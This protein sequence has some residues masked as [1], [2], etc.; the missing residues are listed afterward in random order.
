MT[1]LPDRGNSRI[2][3]PDRDGRGF[4]PIGGSEALVKALFD[5]SPFSTV[6]YDASGH[7]VG[8]NAAFERLFRLTIGDIPP[9]YSVLTD[10]E[11]ERGGHLSLVRRAFQGDVSVLPLVRY[12]ASGLLESAATTWTQGH[13]FPI[14]DASGDVSG[15]VLVH[16][17]LTDRVRAE[18][19]ERS[20]NEQLRG[21]VAEM[22]TQA[23]Q[24]QDQA[25]EMETQQMELEQQAEDLRV[26]IESL[27]EANARLTQATAVATSA[28][29]EAERSDEFAR[30][31]LNS[32]VDPFVVYD[33]EW[34]FQYVNESAR[35]VFARGAGGAFDIEGAVLWDR[36]PELAGTEFER[37]M[38]RSSEQRIPVTFV[39]HYPGT[40]LWSEV[41]CYP[42]PGN[43]LA[44]QWRDITQRRQAEEAR[45]FLARSAEV[46]SQ[47]LERDAIARALAGLLIPRLADWCSIQLLDD[48][49]KLN[50]TA[51]AHVDPA[52]VAWAHEINAR[53]PAD[54]K[55]RTGAHEV[56][57]TGQPMLIPEISDEMLVGAARDAEHLRMLREI[58]FASALTVPLVARGIP[59]GAMTLISAESGRRYGEAELG[60]ASEIGAR[61]ALAL[62]NALAYAE[63]RRARDDAEAER[64]RTAGILETMADAHFVVDRDF[65]FSSVNAAM[66]RNLGVPRDRL[67]GRTL[68][69]AF[70]GFAGTI[71]EESFRRVA[72]EQAEAHF[73]GEYDADGLSIVPEVDAYPAAGGGIAV[74]W[75]DVGPRRRA[76][77][78]LA[79]SERQFRTLADAI[80]TLAWT[81][82]ADGF[83]DWYN[84]RWYEYTG[85]TPEQ[86]EGWGWQSVHDPAMLPEIMTRWKRSIDSGD[87]FE[88]T[89]PLRGADGRF[90]RFLT[91]VVPMRDATGRV[92]RWFGTN[93]DVEAERAAR[94]AAEQARREAEVLRSMAETAN[95]A[96]SQ[97]LSTMSHELRTPLNAI[98]G[99]T[100]LLSLGIRGGLNDAQALDVER[101]SRANQHMTSLVTDLLN[102]ARLDA[103]ELAYHLADVDL[104]PVA[105]DLEPLFAPQLGSKGIT[106][107]TTGWASD[108]ADP[109][110]VRADP[111]KLQQIL[112]N[113]L[114]N[115]VKFTDAGGRV[116]LACARDAS[117]G[118]IRMSV[119]DTGRGIPSNQLERIF[120][121]FVQVDRHRTQ[122]SQQGVG[123]GLSISRDLARGMG[124]EL[125]V[126]SVVGEGSTFTLELPSAR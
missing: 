63:L 110:I 33:R 99:Y 7:I 60:L 40:G 92:F 75:R 86:M 124:G 72:A 90:R 42:M 81:A 56:I 41:Q 111:E 65:R 125:T 39:E 97:F 22:E 43:A 46:L 2:D 36:Y 67:L 11:L 51:V 121:P 103:R 101:I 62:D 95:A 105:A 38:R 78:A 83:I 6:V 61:A 84:A 69:E 118:V 70:P 71:F 13:F 35:A 3:D 126:K 113:L 10:P 82:R 27:Q 29:Q 58:G 109:F 4:G 25:S 15:V 23:E 1:R 108:P 107:D 57:R 98:A 91:R 74:F 50:Q 44:V 54:P 123:L 32:I 49:G 119:A 79:E 45:H 112:L 31:I 5:H 8:A 88:M 12:D 116:A 18:E 24:L 114:T 122:E 73:T 77:S 115:A 52:K 100:Q 120:E 55:A 64:E 102:F 68:W 47:S 93:T 19:A 16:V 59:I 85:T 17:D 20:A 96:K 21:I 9:S 76:E 28:Q 106:F 14:R 94:E 87:P 104:A 89:F 30:G 66:E 37:E 48:N 53:Y 80:P 26:A 117:R 34:R